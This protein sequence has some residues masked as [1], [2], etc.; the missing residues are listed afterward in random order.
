MKKLTSSQTV[1]KFVDYVRVLTT[2]EEFAHMA[3]MAADGE[4]GFGT[5]Y[6]SWGK[7]NGH[8]VY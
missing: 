5:H 7:T 3:K 8:T 2:D 6:Y 1:K 4:M